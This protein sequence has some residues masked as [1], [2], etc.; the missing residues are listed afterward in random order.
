MATTLTPAAYATIGTSAVVKF[1]T[2]LME[3][4]MYL[5]NPVE[6]MSEVLVHKQLNSKFKTDNFLLGLV[7]LGRN[8]FSWASI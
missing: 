4:E 7:Q 6:Y 1:K 2:G 8:H 3:L 5:I